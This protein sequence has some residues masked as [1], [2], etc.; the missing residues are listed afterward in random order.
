MDAGWAVE[1][2]SFGQPDRP[3][4][5][6]P[7]AGLWACT[8]TLLLSGC[9]ETVRQSRLQASGPP[10][11]TP[12]QQRRDMRINDMLNKPHSLAHSLL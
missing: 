10:N 12:I 9:F 8:C 5:A 3:E 1:L 6:W 11:L 4:D 2:L 7:A